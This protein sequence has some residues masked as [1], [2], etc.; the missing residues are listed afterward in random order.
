MSSPF[1]EASCGTLGSAL[2]QGFV[3]AAEPQ[4]IGAQDQKHQNI[5]YEWNLC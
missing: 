5:S 2:S 1:V 3:G 4:G